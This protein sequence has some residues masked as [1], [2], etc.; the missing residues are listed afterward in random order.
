MVCTIGNIKMKGGIK[1]YPPI[2]GSLPGYVGSEKNEKAD[3][4]AFTL[5]LSSFCKRKK[6]SKFTF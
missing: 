4:L 6:N 5:F 1:N 3:E 2:V